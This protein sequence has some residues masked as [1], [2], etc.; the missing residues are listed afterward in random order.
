VLA[1]I[2]LAVGVWGW[3]GVSGEVRLREQQGWVVVSAFGAAIAAIGGVYLVTVAMRSVRLG[4]RQLMFDLA[5]VLG[6]S[7]TVTKRGRLQL[8]AGDEVVETTTEQ[9]VT[10]LV[11]GPG[12]TIVH[13]SDCPIAR[14]KT[15]EE[16]SAADAAAR[17][18]GTC[19]VCSASGASR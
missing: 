16:I 8:H 5:D 11:V 14:N 13:R 19:G 18:L 9:A 7:V 15:V 3:V 4:Q 12:M 6:W 2:G 1:V 10:T 17:N